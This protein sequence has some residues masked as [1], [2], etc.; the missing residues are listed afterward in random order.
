MT[1][2]SLALAPADV[3]VPQTAVMPIDQA[4]HFQAAE[5]RHAFARR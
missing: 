4:L 2:P 1:A 5:L 3:T